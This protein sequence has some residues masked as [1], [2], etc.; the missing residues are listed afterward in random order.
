MNDCTYNIRF[1]LHWIQGFAIF[2]N[3]LFGFGSLYV[4]F[5]QE[6]KLPFNFCLYSWQSTISSSSVRQI[7]NSY[8]TNRAFTKNSEL[9]DQRLTRVI[10]FKLDWQND[11]VQFYIGHLFWYKNREKFAVFQK[12]KALIYRLQHLRSS[13]APNPKNPF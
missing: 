13:S 12:N 9:P 7:N 6:W 11:Y 2:G 4:A 8:E 5:F 1:H 10:K 3:G